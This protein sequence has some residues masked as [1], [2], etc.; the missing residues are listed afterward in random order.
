MI[1]TWLA[2]DRVDVT[3]NI[4]GCFA[5]VRAMD[6]QAIC[7]KQVNIIMIKDKIN[8]IVK[9]PFL[10]CHHDYYYYYYFQKIYNLD[11]V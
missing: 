10:L 1:Q 6:S 7:A 3:I 9:C 11:V 2:R 4:K 8:N 5:T